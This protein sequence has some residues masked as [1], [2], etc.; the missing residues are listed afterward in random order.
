MRASDRAG[1]FSSF[2]V[3]MNVVLKVTKAPRASDMWGL[4]AAQ[5]VCA[6]ANAENWMWSFVS[7]S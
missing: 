2:V 3:G 6:P 1:E 5:T 4:K 7:G